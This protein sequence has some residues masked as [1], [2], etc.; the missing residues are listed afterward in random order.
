MHTLTHTPEFLVFLANNSKTCLFCY[1]L[2]S[3][4]AKLRSVSPNIPQ[5]YAN[6]APSHSQRKKRNICRSRK[7]ISLLCKY[8]VIGNIMRVK[9]QPDRGVSA[10]AQGTKRLL[11]DGTSY[12]TQQINEHPKVDDNC[13]TLCIVKFKY[14][15][16]YIYSHWSPIVVQ[17][18]E[19][20]AKFSKMIENQEMA[21]SG[22]THSDF[23]LASGDQW[24]PAN[25]NKSCSV[26]SLSL[27]H[28]DFCRWLPVASRQSSGTSLCVHPGPILV[29][30]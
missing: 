5:C 24:R 17:M 25:G 26:Q 22:D 30:I 20:V 2:Q 21:K 6:L 29:E 13:R 10:Q 12:T 3:V 15:S 4:F 16:S 18:K 1:F 19:K 7:T 11:V 8:W 9:T 23:G 28:C 27:R 14:F